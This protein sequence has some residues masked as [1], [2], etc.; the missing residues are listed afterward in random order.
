M[1]TS[2][3]NTPTGTTAD[4][5]DSSMEELGFA[6]NPFS[7]DDTDDAVVEQT[8][9]NPQEDEQPDGE[10]GSTDSEPEA[11]DEHVPEEE[12]VEVPSVT[13]ELKGIF[14]DTKDEKEIVTAATAMKELLDTVTKERD[15]ERSAN[16]E[17]VDLLNKH[18]ALID[19]LRQVRD[20]KPFHEA[21]RRSLDLGEDEEIPDRVE[22]E[23][24]YYAYSKKQARLED[25]MIA[26]KKAQTELAAKAELARTKAI[27]M[28]SKFQ[29]DK[30]LADADMENFLAKVTRFMYGDPNTGLLPSDF[31]EVMWKATAYEEDIKAAVTTAVKKTQIDTRNDTIDKIMRKKSVKGD[32]IPTLRSGIVRETHV[33]DELSNLEKVVAPRNNMFE[34][35]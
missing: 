12:E 8:E 3:R 26:D 14:P 32:G 21:V 31:L 11:K 4:A 10:T 17:M 9:E 5:Q 34:A 13:K 20:G 7:S 27:E 1:E 6:R 30:K 29:T 19:L 22:D 33:I 16:G 35:V 28:K 18:P 23:A 15:S 2:E 24:G 25:R